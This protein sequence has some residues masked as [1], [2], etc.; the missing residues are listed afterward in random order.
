MATITFTGTIFGGPHDGKRMEF[1]AKTKLPL[2]TVFQEMQ[3]M[4]MHGHQY[5]IVS[6]D[7]KR[8][9]AELMW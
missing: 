6:F 8:K 4:E 3:R 2:R 7:R 5:R 1:V 9:H